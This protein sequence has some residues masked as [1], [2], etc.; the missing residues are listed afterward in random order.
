[1]EAGDS[2]SPKWGTLAKAVVALTGV[3]VLALILIRFHTFIPLL[4]L[5][6]ITAFLVVP[7][8]R[9]LHTRTRMSWALAANL[10]FLLLLL[11]LI[12]ASTATGYAVVQQLQA[13]FFVVQEFLLEL[14]AQLEMLSQQSYTFG[15]WVLDFGQFDLAPLA[16]QL[17][18]SVQP[19]LGQ[20]S[21]I[22]ASLATGAIEYVASLLFS[23]AVAYF[24]ILDFR[25]FRRMVS[26]IYIP[27]YEDDFRRLRVALIRIWNA[28][29]RGQ[30]LIVASTGI[31]A[32]IV[33]TILGVRFSIGLGILWGVAKFV[34]ILGPIT[35][36]VIAGL[37]GLFQPYNWLGLT[38]FG[39]ALLIVICVTV[40]DQAIDYL[41]VPR[42]MGTSL[43][44]HPVA[45]L[46]GLLVGARLAGVLGLLISAP[47]LASLVILGRYTY[48]KMFDLPPWDPPIDVTDRIEKRPTYLMRLVKWSQ[49]WRKRES[50][51]DS[52]ENE[53][54]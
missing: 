46:L 17:L 21:A 36:G 32:W 42:I 25:R 54:S 37:V 29:L 39:Y 44:L 47:T 15:P 28:F 24:I 3:M 41:L 5:A 11:I 34:P 7:I 53:S 19:V 1:M 20:M 16:E 23:L 8:V 18:S 22:V 31:L 52:D 40:L 38:P 4:V 13:L 14:P 43:N 51:A 10:C 27:G 50:S 45:I 26:E 12:G 6:L 30:L 2:N 48:R 35:A 49:R 9:F 33:L